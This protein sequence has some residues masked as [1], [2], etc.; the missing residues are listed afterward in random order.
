MVAEYTA[1]GIAQVFTKVIPI[2][3]DLITHLRAIILTSQVGDDI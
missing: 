2:L 1:F 3:I